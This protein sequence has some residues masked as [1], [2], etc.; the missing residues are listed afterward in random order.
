MKERYYLAYG[1]NMNL[2]QME[3][4]CPAATV[5]G[6]V[7][8]EDHRLAFRGSGGKY[9]VA[10]ILPEKG[11]RVDGVLWKITPECESSLDRYEGYPH[12]YSK[13]MITVCDKA[14]RQQ[15]VT[16]YLINEPHKSSPAMPTDFYLKGIL[17]GCRQN[18]LSTKP[19]MDA[20]RQTKQE[21]DVAKGKKKETYK[22]WER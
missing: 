4:R 22:T 14:G 15:N 1:S 17:D 8:V 6:N 9:G 7:H 20:V 21:L 18:G 2:D 3:F 10:T 11:S 12:L 5:V 13:E 19:V 16:V